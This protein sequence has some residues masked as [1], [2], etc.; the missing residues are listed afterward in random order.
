MSKKKRIVEKCLRDYQVFGP[1][2]P[3]IPGEI[4]DVGIFEYIRTHSVQEGTTDSWTASS[5]AWLDAK[6]QELKR[7]E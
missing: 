2:Q 7:H 3:C 6:I 4:T 1:L 5:H